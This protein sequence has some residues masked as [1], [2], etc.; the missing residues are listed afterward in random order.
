MYTCMHYYYFLQQQQ[1]NNHITPNLQY[2]DQHFKLNSVQSQ[3]SCTP[4]IQTQTFQ[5]SK[6]QKKSPKK[7]K[8]EIPFKL[9]VIKLTVLISHQ[10]QFKNYIIFTSENNDKILVCEVFLC[11]YC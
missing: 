4:R 1:Y 10:S 5:F 7:Q 3:N 6:K 8:I 11:T 2:S 9:C